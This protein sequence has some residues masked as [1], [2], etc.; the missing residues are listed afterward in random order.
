M[1]APKVALAPTAART[2][3][4]V[5][6]AAITMM[7][8]AYTSAMLVRQGDA[9]DW[10]SIHLPGILYFNTLVLIVS[11]GAYVAGQ[12]RLL[13]GWRAGGTAAPEGTRWLHL[14]LGLGLLFVAGQAVAWTQLAAQGVFLA[15]NPA[16]SFF[17]VLTGLHA[18]HLLGGVCGMLYVFSRLRKSARGAVAP[19]AGAVDAMGLYW[20]FMGVLWIYLLGLM[21]LRL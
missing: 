8:A 4:W 9:P 7:F 15:S 12:R 20:H 2:G 10:T 14:T 5:G 6:I 11:S 16:S 1:T 13:A 21:A 19:P 17:Y 18:L 3:V